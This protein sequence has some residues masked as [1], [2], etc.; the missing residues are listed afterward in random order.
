[1]SEYCCVH[2]KFCWGCWYAL[3][4]NSRV[5][6]TQ[7]ENSGMQT[8]SDTELREGRASPAV[9][10]HTP[11][12]AQISFPK[13]FS[14]LGKQQYGNGKTVPILKCFCYE[15]RSLVNISKK[16]TD[17]S[18]ILLGKNTRKKI[19]LSVFNILSW[20]FWINIITAFC[21]F[22]FLQEIFTS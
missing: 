13:C 3:R 22:F 19:F 10:I 6:S 15:E 2:F 14:L 5:E 8:A 4:P 21:V 11:L 17:L 9:C 12:P 20:G 7:G 16:K 1:M 18:A